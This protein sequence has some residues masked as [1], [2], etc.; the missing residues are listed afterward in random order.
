MTDQER[1]QELIEVYCDADRRERST[2]EIDNSP[3]LG[4]ILDV[5][6]GQ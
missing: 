5:M 4:E 1:M 6:N 3:T 2:G